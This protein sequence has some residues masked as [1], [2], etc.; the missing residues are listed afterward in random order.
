MMTCNIHK[1]IGGT[2]RRYDPDVVLLQ[3]VEASDHL[4]LFADMKLKN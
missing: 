3:E 4:P 2:D 1:R